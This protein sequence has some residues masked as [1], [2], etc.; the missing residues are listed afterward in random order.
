MLI[1]IGFDKFDQHKKVV[2]DSTQVINP[3]WLVIG[4]SGSG[5][6]HRIR[7]TIEQAQ[8]TRVRFHVFDV[9][10][11][12]ALPSHYTS[13]ITFSNSSDFGMNPLKI[14][15]D[16]DFGG[17]R[18]RV[19]AFVSMVN[20]YSVRLGINQEGTLRS[21]LYDL[22]SANWILSDQPAT[23]T[24]RQPT[25]LDLKRFIYAKLKAKV[26][27]GN[28]DVFKNLTELNRKVTRLEKEMKETHGR[29]I[30][31][32]EREELSKMKG[33]CIEAFRRYLS[34]IETGRELDDFIR[35]DSKDVLKSVHNRID[36]L[37]SSGV[38]KDSL[39]MFERD[40]PVWR[41]D[42]K[43]LTK[44]EQG[45][46]VEMFIE[47]IF[48]AARRR[49]PTDRIHSYIVL[50]EAHKFIA[51]EPDH[52]INIVI[53]EARKFG[54]GLMLASQ[55]FQHFSDDILN[56]CATKVVLGV[57]EMFHDAMS[58]KFGIEMK[59]LRYIQPRRTGIVQVKTRELTGNNRYTDV[60]LE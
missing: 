11:D 3:H 27:G 37:H 44:E 56:N 55:N 7:R 49:G 40:K 54:L 28:N 24:K 53:R 12:I 35:Y 33:D 52:I 8:G 42:I 23:W 1:N 59:K 39:P 2:W 15:P 9:H 38:F 5:K 17:V 36:S 41:Y 30:T 58:R 22:Y 29:K 51:E 50:D 10:G 57:D 16:P 25:L 4:T 18:Q 21:L 34:S 19:R 46:L 14:H 31:D 45:F 48:F 43:S 20:R 13:T 26:I 60:V 6:T 47:E 32:L